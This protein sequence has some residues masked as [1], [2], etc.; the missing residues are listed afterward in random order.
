M[1]N[2]NHTW[3]HYA[4]DKLVNGFISCCGPMS[5]TV[6][7]GCIAIDTH[8]HSLYSRCSVTSVRRIILRAAQIGLGGIAVL[9]HNDLR[10]AKDAAKCAEELKRNGL[11]PAGFTVISGMEISSNAGHIGALF[12]NEVIPMK[13][14]LRETVEQIHMAGGLAIAVHPFLRSGIGDALFD[15]PFDAVEIESG[16]AFGRIPVEKSQSLLNDERMIGMAK[17]GSSDAHY[18]RAIGMCFTVIKSCEI[19]PD[20]I[21]SHISGCLTSP[22]PSSTS[23][24]I[25]KMLGNMT[26]HK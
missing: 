18:A 2:Y 14:G 10:S 20:L 13:L 15:A 6:P 26:I 16:S 19:T 22:Q 5:I 4:A 17:L 25:R 7:P 11:I 12:V 8:I 3:R 21:R 1:G 23:L 24:R 9:D